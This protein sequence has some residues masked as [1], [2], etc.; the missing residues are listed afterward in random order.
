MLLSL[1]ALALTNVKTVYVIDL[2]VS[3]TNYKWPFP[4]LLTRAS[5]LSILFLFAGMFE[6][7]MYFIS[8]I[9]II[10][11]VYVYIFDI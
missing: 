4:K 7:S 9:W 11:Y 3:I 8:V 10:V 1:F 2:N 5:F 6:W